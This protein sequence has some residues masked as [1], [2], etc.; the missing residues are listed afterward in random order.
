MPAV[1]PP[2]PPAVGKLLKATSWNIDREPPRGPGGAEDDENLRELLEYYKQRVED[3]EAANHDAVSS[4]LKEIAVSNEELHKVR[5][6]LRVK[7]E[8]IHSL[9]KALSEANVQLYDESA[10]VLKLT[11][12]NEELRVQALEDRRKIQ[13]L[14]ALT[15]PV[16]QEVTFFKDCRPQMVQKFPELQVLVRKLQRIS[17]PS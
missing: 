8:E 11:A 17:N 5:W 12:E 13:H 4:S 16:S 15:Q 1:A 6:D 2:E 10:T 7:R 9:Q 3:R 14:L